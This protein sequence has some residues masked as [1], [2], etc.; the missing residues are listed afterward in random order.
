[1]LGAILRASDTV[2]RYCESHAQRWCMFMVRAHRR[3][4]S[5]ERRVLVAKIRQSVN[6][7]LVRAALHR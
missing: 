6:A 1:M 4:G 7:S 2:R 5:A 3:V